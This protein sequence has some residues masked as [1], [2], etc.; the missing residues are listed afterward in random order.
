[1]CQAA[2]KLINSPSS[3]LLWLLPLT[4]RSGT[5]HPSHR[6]ILTLSEITRDSQLT[7]AAACCR[8]RR[9]RTSRR[10]VS[11]HASWRLSL[12][13]RAGQC[14]VVRAGVVSLAT[15]YCTIDWREQPHV[16]RPSSAP[17]SSTIFLGHQQIFSEKY[18]CSVG[19][20]RVLVLVC[21]C[22]VLTTRGPLSDITKS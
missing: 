19:E 2:A 17:R 6:D 1:M 10:L 9:W 13:V 20:R 21:L 5:C 18:R 3:W 16:P 4:A 11:Q 7:S 8:G 12:V 22:F 14:W 15:S